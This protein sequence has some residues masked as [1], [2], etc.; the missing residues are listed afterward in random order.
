MGTVLYWQTIYRPTEVK[1]RINNAAL[2]C[3]IESE[4]EEGRY[5]LACMGK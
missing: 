3:T 1:D 2:C 4:D 5:T